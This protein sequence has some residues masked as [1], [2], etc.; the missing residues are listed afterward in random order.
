MVETLELG[1]GHPYKQLREEVARGRAEES[2]GEYYGCT[3]LKVTF[4]EKR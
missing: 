2:V 1:L 3:N 4:Q